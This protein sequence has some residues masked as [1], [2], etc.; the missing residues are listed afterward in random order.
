MAVLY[1]LNYLDET[2]CETF[3]NHLSLCQFA[4]LS[5]DYYY[6]YYYYFLLFAPG[7]HFIPKG[8]ELDEKKLC[9]LLNM[10]LKCPR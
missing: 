9:K 6:Y 10:C 2:F 1:Q 7:V 8:G 4:F 3:F 5:Y